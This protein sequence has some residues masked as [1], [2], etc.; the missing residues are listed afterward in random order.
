MNKCRMCGDYV[1]EI[2]LDSSGVCVNC[3]HEDDFEEE[4]EEME[5]E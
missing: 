5:E 3:N 2:D 1:H 4:D